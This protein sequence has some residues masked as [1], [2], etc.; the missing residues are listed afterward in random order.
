M[1]E[2]RARIKKPGRLVKSPALKA[3]RASVCCGASELH[4]WQ[5]T[6]EIRL[7]TLNVKAASQGGPE[8]AA[9]FLESLPRG[10]AIWP[11]TSLYDSGRASQERSERS[12]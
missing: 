2:V 7:L 8:T 5:H 6:I 12:E 9:V 10:K 11:P 1:W 4:A 3:I